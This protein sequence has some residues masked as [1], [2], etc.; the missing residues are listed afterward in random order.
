MFFTANLAPNIIMVGPTIAL[1]VI[2]NL[3]ILGEYRA[4]TEYTVSLISE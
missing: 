2:L 4:L 3:N 1:G